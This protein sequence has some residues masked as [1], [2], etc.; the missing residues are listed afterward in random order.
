MRYSLLLA[1]A[2]LTL[3]FACNKKISEA[4]P[5]SSPMP[6][7]NSTVTKTLAF[8]ESE[9]LR[10]GE[11]FQ[12]EKS[13][14]T[15][16][17]VEVNLDSRCPTGV[18]CVQEGEAQVT[19]NVNGQPQRVTIDVNEKTT[20]RVRI[21]GGTVEILSLDPYPAAEVRIKPEDRRLRIRMVKSADM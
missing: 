18:N 1:L 19:V 4:S 3:A 9:S 7:G 16:K 10:L 6:D 20:A 12:V 17:F 5:T 21:P 14:A 13:D 15:F 11:G 2:V 8:G